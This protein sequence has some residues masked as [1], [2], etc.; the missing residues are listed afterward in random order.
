MID[1]TACVNGK[2]YRIIPIGDEHIFIEGENE[3]TQKLDDGLFDQMQNMSLKNDES[4][5]ALRRLKAI[6]LIISA[7][8]LI[9]AYRLY[10]KL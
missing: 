4:K 1:N 6:C 9:I 10:L 2:L 7:F 3:S 5:S 8:S